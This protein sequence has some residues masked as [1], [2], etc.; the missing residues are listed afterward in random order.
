[1]RHLAFRLDDNQQAMAWQ[2]VALALVDRLNPNDRERML[3]WPW[4]PQLR[5]HP[6]WT[7]AA[8]GAIASPELI[9]RFHR[10]EDDLLGE[11]VDQPAALADVPFDTVMAVADA[12]LPIGAWRALEPV[13]LLQTAGRWADAH[14]LAGRIL[15][16]APAGREGDSH[17]DIA[18]FVELAA[19]LAGLVTA[20]ADPNVSGITAAARDVQARASDLAATWRLTDDDR[21]R[22]ARQFLASVTAPADAVRALLD[23][24]SDPAATAD[25]LD[26]VARSLQDA[27]GHRGAP[28]AQRTYVA[29]AWQIAAHLY[30][31]DA[32]V[33]HADPHSSR[34]LQAAHRGAQ[35]LRDQ[36]GAM[37]LVPVPQALIRFCTAVENLSSPGDLAEATAHLVHVAAPIR[38]LLLPPGTSPV[39]VAT[40]T[41]TTAEP[42][43][44]VCVAGLRGTP[45][46]DV[47][48]VRPSEI[49]HIDMTV[50]LSAWPD[51]ADTC[52]VEPVTTL[53]RSVLSLPV[54][55]FYRLDG[56]ADDAGVLLTGTQPLH[57]AVE[58]PIQSP[59]IDCPLVVEFASRERKET[60]TVAG[61]RRLRVR[62]FD[63]SSDR[64][65]EHEQTDAR[66]LAMYDALT[67]PDFDTEDVRAFCRLFGACV[68]AAQSI[69][70][71]KVF[72]RGTRVSEATFHDELESRL[73]ADP[74]LGGRLTR[75]DAVAGGFDDLLH[76]DVIAEL[77]VVSNKA[78]TVADCAKYLGQPTQYGV[79]RGSQLSVLVVLDHSPKQAPPGVIDNYVDW[80]KPELHGLDDP[81]YPSLV[82]VLIVNT[83]LPVPSTWSRR[84]IA[85]VPT[86][87]A[88]AGD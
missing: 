75:R 54:Y 40:P 69:M 30:R 43:Y 72:R 14:T 65:T 26:A 64:L 5:N 34:F 32:A 49:Y 19:R 82:G 37:P 42:P 68:R 24:T 67:G 15:A 1:L 85:T 9:D 31:Y 59:A 53:P 51:W 58:Q 27:A 60:I 8:L 21:D 12:R 6:A 17:R 13:E 55:V 86:V 10:R 20:G 66:L 7:R 79:G 2:S 57:C 50:R 61:Y 77:K 39:P 4:P 63:P 44:A 45:I 25:A 33:R 81:K 62:P 78:V 36:I 56:P 47:L 80:L 83:N 23:S 29:A 88:H 35:V 3:T 84:S 38:L 16:A 73:R 70:F 71:D 76:D 74:E 28:T 48:V 41:E 87:S 22:R 52:R 46:T 18:G 11:L